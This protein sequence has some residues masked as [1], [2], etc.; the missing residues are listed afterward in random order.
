MQD[1]RY[2]VAQWATGHTGRHT[3]Q[4]LIEHPLYDLVG[5]RVY[6]EEK[7]GRDAGEI[8]RTEPTGVIATREIE[9][10][11]AAKPDCVVYMPLLE[12]ESID[13]MCR[14]LESG[15]N[16]VTIVPKFYHPPSIDPEVRKSLEAACARGGTSLYC[17]GGSPDFIHEMV[18]MTFALLQRRLDRVSIVQFA[19]VSERNSPEFMARFFGY[20]PTGAHVD[21][22]RKSITS[23][24]ADGDSFRQFAEAVGAPLDDV[25]ATAE[26]AVATKAV[27]LALATIEAGTVGAW[28]TIVTGLRK[29]KPFLEFSRTF[30][31]TKDI[32]PAWLMRDSGW[33]VM[34]EG[35]A[36]IE[37]EIKF[38]RENYGSITPGYNGHTAVNAIP[39]VCGAAP[40]IR[41]T[42][43]LRLVPYFG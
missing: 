38:A 14:L 21:E 41:T 11:I 9:E 28:R 39:A 40:G 32:E 7:A 31:V 18:P 37:V 17:T 10:I 2:R 4:K 23:H 29:G 25:I 6:S 15:A 34:V 30:F 43:E 33:H 22:V 5:V 8:G 26:P 27:T 35:D 1:N 19:D 36:P 13:D 20:A 42:D 24:D 16:I 3:L 12:H